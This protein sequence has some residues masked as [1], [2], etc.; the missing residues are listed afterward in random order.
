MNRIQPKGPVQ[1]Y[2]TYGI[3]MPKITH[4]R[5]LSCE[6]IECEH[7]QRGWITRV[8]VSTELGVR[9]ARY[10]E[11]RCGRRFTKVFHGTVIEFTFGAGQKCF[12]EHREPNGRP[13][14]YVVRDGDWR[15]ASEPV[16]MLG[17]NEWTDRFRAAT[18]NLA[19]WMRKG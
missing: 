3:R 15:A 17:V 12:R 13:A 19:A 2:R 4:W 8:D 14:L 16:T 1:A 11:T 9:Q 5:A 10:I 18:E 6:D 7:W